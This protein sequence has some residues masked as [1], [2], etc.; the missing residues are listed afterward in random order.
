M[1]TIGKEL[2]GLGISDR[3]L[4]ELNAETH[5]FNENDLLHEIGGEVYS[6]FKVKIDRAQFD[7]D[8][9][10]MDIK[11]PPQGKGALD[12][13][14]MIQLSEKTS[15]HKKL[16]ETVNKLRGDISLIGENWKKMAIQSSLK[17]MARPKNLWVRNE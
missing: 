2:K 8:K 9:A 4:D 12:P 13:S 11:E 10:M 3:Q 7:M 16:I 14:A 6:V 5:T 17:R 1:D 15:I